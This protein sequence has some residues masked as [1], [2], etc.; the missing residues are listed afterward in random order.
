MSSHKIVSAKNVSKKF[1]RN[2]KRSMI[3]GSTDLVRDLLGMNTNAGD[4]RADEFWAVRNLSFSIEKGETLGLIG[5]NGSG[6][7]TLLRLMTGIFPPDEGEISVEGKVGAL[8]SLG[9]GFNA[10]MTG[11]EN[12]YLNGAILGM[13]RAEIR[14]N[15]DAIVD[16]AE[17]GEFLDAPVSSYSSGMTVRLGFSIAAHSHADLLIIDEVLSVGD[18]AFSIK[19]HR[20]MSEFRQNGGTTVL[21][22]HNNQLIRN[23]CK[24]AIWL[25]HGNCRM[26]GNVQDVCSEYEYVLTKHI[27]ADKTETHSR[28]NYDPA[29]RITGVEFL[30]KD[31]V[32]KDVFETGEYF[33]MR[34]HVECDREVVDPIFTVTI[35]NLESIVVISN[36]SNFDGFKFK[37]MKGKHVVEF[38]IEKLSLKASKYFVSLTFVEKDLNYHLEWHEKAHVF[39]V[40]GGPIS[41]GIFNPY[42]QWKLGKLDPSDRSGS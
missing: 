39:S 1:C 13:N 25:E 5:A 34:I 11:R 22:S 23:V 28:L 38:E 8:I 29:T 40:K 9:A 42:P 17:L 26:A 33:K 18:L 4:L 21:V 10:Q 7:S 19:C 32:E 37:P 36:Y 3:Y 16:F 12:I 14:K 6:K 27:G 41:Y 2:L 20:K 35:Q 24:Q 31:G 30:S 15:F